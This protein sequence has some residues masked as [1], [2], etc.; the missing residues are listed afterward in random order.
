MIALAFPAACLSGPPEDFDTVVYGGTSWAV[1]AAVQAGKMGKR[2]EV[3][4]G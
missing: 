3:L 2:V 1:A 4:P